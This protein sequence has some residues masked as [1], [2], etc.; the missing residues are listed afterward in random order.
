MERSFELF[1]KLHDLGPRQRCLARCKLRVEH[2][3]G[4]H[5]LRVRRVPE[6]RPHHHVEQL[7]QNIKSRI[8]RDRLDIVNRAVCEPADQVQL[9]RDALAHAVAKRWVVDARCQIIFVGDWQGVN[10]IDQCDKLP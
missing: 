1:R 4:R 5:S 2:S 10:G 6:R 7:A 9:R 3:T 8:R